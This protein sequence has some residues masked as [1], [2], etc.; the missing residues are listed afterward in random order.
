MR[1]YWE[2]LKRL[3]RMRL[4]A[5]ISM[6]LPALIALALLPSCSTKK[7]TAF[8]RQWQAFNTRYNVSYN[9]REHFE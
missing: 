6:L 2:A 8:S 5:R 3:E 1:Q 9:G 4:Y 7:N